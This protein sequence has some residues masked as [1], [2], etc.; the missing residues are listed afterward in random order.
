M[1]KLLLFSLG[2]VALFFAVA[3]HSNGRAPSYVPYGS[4]ERSVPVGFDISISAVSVLL[5]QSRNVKYKLEAFNGCFR[6]YVFY[7][8]LAYH[9]LISISLCRKD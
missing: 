9:P 4:S 6:W 2:L 1:A 7:L 3:A 5:P 8:D